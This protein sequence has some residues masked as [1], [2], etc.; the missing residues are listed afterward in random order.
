MSHHTPACIERRLWVLPVMAGVAVATASWQPYG[1]DAIDLTLRHAPVSLVHP[2]GTDH[3]GRDVLSRLM[4]GAHRTFAVVAIVGAM[5]LVLG[6]LLG[7][8]AALARGWASAA[9]LRISEF[10]AVTPALLIAIVVTSIFGLDIVT[11]G[12]ALGLGAWGPFALLS[13][14]LT[15]RALGEP[16]VQAARALGAGRA[17]LVL[18]H[19]WPVIIDTQL[20][21]LGAKLG[22]AAIAYAAIAFLG[23]G[24]DTSRPDWGAMIFEYRLFVFDSPLLLIWPG[25]AIIATCVG[26]RIAFGGDPG[27]RV[28][29]SGEEA[30]DVEPHES[31]PVA[32]GAPAPYIVPRISDPRRS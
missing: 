22:R 6:T 24:A 32:Q 19:I 12:I 2:L 29:A 23:L 20:A 25:L 13:Y 30:R 3:L 4:L 1:P 11:A 21:Y 14:G 28:P 16:Y 26:L 18:S 9:L 17:R 10:V 8:A 31:G 7:T 15:R 5:C 27:S